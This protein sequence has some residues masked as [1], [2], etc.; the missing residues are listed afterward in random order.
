MFAN[1]F[2]GPYLSVR[3]LLIPTGTDNIFVKIYSKI[4]TLGGHTIQDDQGGSEV[5]KRAH[6]SR[7]YPKISSNWVAIVALSR[8][9]SNVKATRF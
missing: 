7:F 2:L 1:I 5:L 8:R 9:D 6:S 3:L 4:L